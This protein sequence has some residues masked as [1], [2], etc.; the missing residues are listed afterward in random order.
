MELGCWFRISCA[1]GN[2]YHANM[3]MH[4]SS[5]NH[6]SGLTCGLNDGL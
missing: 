3:N 6:P 5:V 4:G 1:V 2:G